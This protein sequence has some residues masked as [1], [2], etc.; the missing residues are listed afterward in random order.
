MKPVSQRVPG[1]EGGFTRHGQSLSFCRLALLLYQHFVRVKQL[2]GLLELLVAGRG[3][4]AGFLVTPEI[5]GERALQLE[6][7][8]VPVGR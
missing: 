2:A 7:D 6:F 3:Y 8:D 4:A 1:G 5:P